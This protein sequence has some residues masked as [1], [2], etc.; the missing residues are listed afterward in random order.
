MFSLLKH[1]SEHVEGWVQ[2]LIVLET[3]KL[4]KGEDEI[5]VIFLSVFKLD[6]L[7]LEHEPVFH[8]VVSLFIMQR[9]QLL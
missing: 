4:K 9:S 1:G 2:E 3:G 6:L 5:V 7:S 8:G